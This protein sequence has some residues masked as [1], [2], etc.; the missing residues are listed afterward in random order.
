MASI[1]S[2]ISEAISFAGG[3]IRH[4]A[5]SGGNFQ[6][7]RNASGVNSVGHFD[8]IGFKIEGTEEIIEVGGGFLVRLS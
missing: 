1:S 5:G 6:Y 8:C 7:D 2:L 4:T 3:G